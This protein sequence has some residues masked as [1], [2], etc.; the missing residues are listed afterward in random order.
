MVTADRQLAG[1]AARSVTLSEVVDTV[2]C[3]VG[4]KGRR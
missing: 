3:Y 1:G 2:Y 4:T